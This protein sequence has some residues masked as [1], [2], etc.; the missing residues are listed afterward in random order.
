MFRV[1]CDYFVTE[2]IFYQAIMYDIIYREPCQH[3]TAIQ[4]DVSRHGL[5]RAYGPIRHSRL[6]AAM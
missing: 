5:Q 4:L 2:K 3:F 6:L 1:L